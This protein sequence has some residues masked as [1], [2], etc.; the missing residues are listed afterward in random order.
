MTWERMVSVDDDREALIKQG[1][2]IKIKQGWNALKKGKFNTTQNVIM[3]LLDSYNTSPI[4]T[5]DLWAIK[6]YCQIATPSSPTE[7]ELLAKEYLRKRNETYQIR[8]KEVVSHFSQYQ[9]G[10][11]DESFEDWKRITG[12]NGENAQKVFLGWLKSSLRNLEERVIED[13]EQIEL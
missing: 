8:N 9:L 1:E 13:G 10:I 5:T 4:K 3:D 11:L 2:L 6:Y 7:L 12:H